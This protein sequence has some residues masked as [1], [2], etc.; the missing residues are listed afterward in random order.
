MG[1]GNRQPRG[2]SKAPAWVVV[3]TYL[4]CWGLGGF[5]A[6]SAQPGDWPRLVA[7]IFLIVWPLTGASPV[8]VIRAWRGVE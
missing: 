4:A 6:L 1:N 7:S 2:V 8:E 3:V 5:L